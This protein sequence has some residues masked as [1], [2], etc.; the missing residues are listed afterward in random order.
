MNRFAKLLDTGIRALLGIVI[1][2]NGVLGQNS[3]T[4]LRVRA[5]DSHGAVIP[6]ALVIITDSK[7][8]EERAVT[9]D[10]GMCRFDRLAPGT[11]SLE[12][13]A[14]G[15]ARVRRSDISIR[16]GRRETVELKLDVTIEGQTASITATTNG[17]S[18]DPG[19]SAAALVLKGRDLDAL[20]EDPDELTAALQA[21]AGPAAGPSGG[22]IFIDGFLATRGAPA[23]SAIREV[24]INQNP[25]AAEHDRI[26][27]GRIEIF[28]KP[29]G[30]AFHGSAFG[31]F[32]DEMLNSRNPFSVSRPDFLL[33]A[34][35]GTL[36]GPAAKDR[37]SF[38]INFFR[39][40]IDDS[41]VIN[42]T[43][44][45]DDFQPVAFSQTIRSPRRFLDLSTRFDYQLD[46]N[47]T[48]IGRYSYAHSNQQNLGIGG[49]ALASRGFDAAATDQVIQFSETAILGS[50]AVNEIRFQYSRSRRSQTGDG[51][52][53]SINV[54][55]AFSGGGAT[56]AFS[57]NRTER[58]ELQNHTTRV[59][60]RHTL[61]FGGRL[62]GAVVSDVSPANF[63]GTFTFA[64]GQA[65]ILD[66][67]NRPVL[68][69]SGK[70]VLDEISSIERYRRTLLFLQ[71]GIAPLEIR[72]MGGG[73]SLFSVA[74]GNPFARV[75]QFEFG[76][77]AQ[78]DWRARPN[79]TLS[80]GIRYEAQTNVD[81]NLNVAPRV[82]F[83]WSPGA[84]PGR[85]VKTVI[86]GGTGVFF[87]RFGELLSLQA[88]RFD[89]VRQR[90]V[91][92]ADPAILD[93]FPR[94]P[95]IGSLA[96]SSAPQ[97]IWR[98]ASD[99]RSPYTVMSS[100]SIERQ[101]PRGFTL[102]AAYINAVGFHYFRGRSVNSR[103]ASAG[104]G[105]TGGGSNAAR[106][107][108]TVFAYE[109]SG[110]FRQ[111]L[112]AV[113][114][115]N[116][117]NK[118]FTLFA[119]YILGK[120]NS[121]ADGAGSFPADS[122]DLS[123]EYGRSS[124]DVRH[125][126]YAGGSIELPW[127]VT[128]NP[129]VMASSGAPFNITTGIDSNGDRLFTDRPAFAGGQRGPNV[130]E[131][132]FG[133]FDLAPG[134]G[135]RVIPRNHGRGPGSLFV[136]LRL[137]RTIGFGGGKTSS[138]SQPGRT[139][140]S[141][142]AGVEAPYKLSVSVIAYNVFNR[143]NLGS[144]VGNLTSPFFGR[145]NTLSAGGLNLVTSSMASNRRIDLQVSFTF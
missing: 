115:F 144:P 55:E 62:R 68:D 110:V 124:F 63:A 86:R 15:F 103:D 36:S 100:V 32:N 16:P 101:M 84:S 26:G 74:A 40:E 27:Y 14:R 12:V 22:Q 43:V 129:F 91:I 53:P 66:S 98:V 69:E 64:G 122:S 71:Q 42:A 21:L 28:T 141:A 23:K 113:S 17:L 1:A 139:S 34:Y 61:K 70:P 143:T 57:V 3:E 96:A 118:R 94:V 80:I 77:F 130:R 87:E 5:I 138:A 50:S 59:A 7:G 121:D 142:G 105:Q 108:F 82:A 90:Q 44:L 109:S 52:I 75:R 58:W 60:G 89:G 117:L 114:T 38:S 4:S 67:S 30:A 35:G 99:L 125:R 13:T 81:N 56:V 24:Q 123:T 106:D 45:G 19:G 92:T 131:T 51:S 102:T 107:A 37:A 33:R 83:A 79:F 39:R 41:S 47:N 29:G 134:P 133:A 18:T 104:L 8:G 128:L 137:A 120:A 11:Y 116:R 119:S 10:E 20:P 2:A 48:L 93:L 76:A 112:L 88:I 72:A 31:F 9:G 97:T 135:A 65:P 127:Q 140:Q 85:P 136:N 25:F 126:A 145:S 46:K 132:A 6:G 54:L 73:A 78:D 49:F 95:S 111:H